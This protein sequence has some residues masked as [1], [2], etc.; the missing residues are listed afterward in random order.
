M[1][2]GFA[3]GEEEVTVNVL[4]HIR[5]PYDYYLTLR[6]LPSR[7]HLVQ[8]LLSNTAQSRRLRTTE[9]CFQERAR[10]LTSMNTVRQWAEFLKC[11]IRA[12][13]TQKTGSLRGTM[14]PTRL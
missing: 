14:M 3:A 1:A 12:G 8:D 9:Q 5:A 7:Y 6:V 11:P 13:M 10:G 2:A 4:Q